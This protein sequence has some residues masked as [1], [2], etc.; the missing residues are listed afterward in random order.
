[1]KVE[2][3]GKVFLLSGL[4]CVIVIWLSEWCCV[5]ESCLALIKWDDTRR[6]ELKKDKQ[7]RKLI[8]S[9]SETDLI[10]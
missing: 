6:K 3:L 10:N 9:M 8:L 7:G 5:F 4:R 2:L 1:M